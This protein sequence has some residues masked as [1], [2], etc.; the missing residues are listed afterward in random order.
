[1]ASGN[2]GAIV[3]RTG[4]G[5]EPWYGQGSIKPEPWHEPGRLNAKRPRRV[6]GAGVHDS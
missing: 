6:S 1:M 3:D 2:R 4:A 5:V